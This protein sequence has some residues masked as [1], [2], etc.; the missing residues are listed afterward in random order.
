[1]YVVLVGLIVSITTFAILNLLTSSI[2]DRTERKGF[3]DKIMIR[4]IKSFMISST[5]FGCILLIFLVINW[6][7]Y[8]QVVGFTT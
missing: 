3:E 5:V 8:G 7:V 6:I 4:V 2:H 1:M